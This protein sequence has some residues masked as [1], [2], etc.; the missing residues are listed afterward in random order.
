MRCRHGYSLYLRHLNFRVFCVQVPPRPRPEVV[1]GID[2]GPLA[3]NFPPLYSS[4]PLL[5]SRPQQ[6]Q[7]RTPQI[8]NMRLSP[9]QL[10]ITTIPEGPLNEKAVAYSLIEAT[11]EAF[12]FG[13]Q[14]WRILMSL[15]LQFSGTG[16]GSTDGRGKYQLQGSSKYRRWDLRR[17]LSMRR[18]STWRLRRDPQMVR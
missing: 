8:I 16:S 14:R 11:D 3:E 12:F 1:P 4:T 7:P 5:P 2:Y 18:G 9:R 13:R 15:V 6:Q 17:L 10:A